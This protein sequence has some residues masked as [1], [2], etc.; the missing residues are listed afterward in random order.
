[1]ALLRVA[2]PPLLANGVVSII[3]WT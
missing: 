3:G 2:L 1:V